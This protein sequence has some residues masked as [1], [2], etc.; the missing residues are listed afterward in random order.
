MW[1][2]A[3]RSW[4]MKRYD[5]PSWAWRSLKRFRIWARMDT[6]SAETGSSSSTTTFAVV[7]LPHPDSPTS[8][9]VLPGSIVKEMSSTARTTATWRE[10]T[11]PR[12]TGKCFMR[13]L[14]SRT[15][16]AIAATRSPGRGRREPA[17][18]RLQ[19]RH[20][21]LGRR[22]RPAAVHDLGAARVE[23]A[24]RRRRRR[25]RRLA[26]GRGEPLAIV[27]EPRNGLE[28]RLRVRMRRRVVDLLHRA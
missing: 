1:A 10:K 14:A 26:G 8:P 9:S 7:V 13:L 5:T 11:P 23:R 12:F 16:P 2:T 19:V 21:V 28:Q 17:A 20:A 27:T 3:A 15:G 4:A 22:L 24:P 18:A 25:I 6:S